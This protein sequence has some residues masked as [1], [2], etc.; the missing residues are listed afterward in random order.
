[1]QDLRICLSEFKEHKGYKNIVNMYDTDKKLDVNNQFERRIIELESILAEY[2]QL[3]GDN[4]LKVGN[5]QIYMV[6]E[7]HKIDAQCQINFSA[8]I[9]ETY[10]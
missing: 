10:E 9:Y 5:D 3:Y 2:R 6:N 8:E 1:M 4:E 7:V